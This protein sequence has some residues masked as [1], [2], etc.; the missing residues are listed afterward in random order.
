MGLPAAFSAWRPGQVAA[1]ASAV[2][3]PTRFS[4]LV[5]PTGFGKSLVY[6]GIAAFTGWRT[7]ILTSTKALQRQLEKEF[8]R[9][10]GTVLIQGQR[11]YI[12][13]ALEPGGELSSVF[14]ATGPHH[15]STV[16]Q[17]PCH[18]GVNCSR[19]ENGCGYYDTLREA[20]H[21]QT[22]IIITNYAFWLSLA[23][24][25]II[26]LKPDL[27][28]CDEAHAAPDALA[29][30]IGTTLSPE[31]VGSVLQETL[32]MAS[33]RTAKEWQ[34]WARTKASTLKNHLQ[35]ARPKTRDG[36]IK[37]RRATTLLQSLERIA[38]L[39]THMLVISDDPTGGVKA[40]VLWAAG[41]AEDWLWRGTPRVVLTS[42]TMTAH[43]AEHVGVIRKHLTLH[44][45]GDGF[46]VSRRPV[47]VSPAKS[48]F[49]EPIRVDFRT[50]ALDKRA[51]LTHID[52]VLGA[53]ADRKGIIHTISYGRR[54][55][56][57]SESAHR[58]RMIIH[59]RG[60][61]AARIAEFRAAP[62]GAILVSPALTTGYDFPFD[63]C[64]YQVVM[65]IPFVDAKDPVAKART[66]IDPKYP[67]HVAMQQLVQMVGRGMRAE[68]DQCETFVMDG[69]ASWFLSKH[70]DLA[71]RWFRRAV[72][73]LKAGETQAPPPSL[74]SQGTTGGESPTEAMGAEADQGAEE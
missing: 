3:S 9:L 13:T 34:D 4:G 57:V 33:K 51:W 56:L 35:G 58:D 74:G 2:D 50:S 45:A 49:G 26:T 66:Q 20:V 32:P 37:I 59:G 46:P 61:M 53:R 1:I 63:Q 39:P 41:M 36:V 22:Q 19:R 69:H 70:A 7:V 68:T 64:E 21:P 47:Y 28:V 6:M 43:T 18:F 8:G 5:L 25:P 15:T 42:A 48:M 67:M 55:W 27:L 29:T 23:H 30:A 52:T 62:P 72:T 12:C 54:D 24:A 16:D 40:D 14:M 38:T 60:D 44:E 10:V 31:A 17:G 65:K 73:K 11:N 71:P